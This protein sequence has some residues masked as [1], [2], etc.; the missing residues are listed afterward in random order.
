VAVAVAVLVVQDTYKE[1]LRQQLVA[2]LV[3]ADGF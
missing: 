3:A 1:T 2:D